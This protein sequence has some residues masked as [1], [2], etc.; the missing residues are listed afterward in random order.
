MNLHGRIS[1]R[2]D[3][4]SGWMLG[5]VELFAVGDGFDGEGI[6]VHFRNVHSSSDEEGLSGENE[7]EFVEEMKQ[8]TFQIFAVGFDGMRVDH[9]DGVDLLGDIS[10]HAHGRLLKRLFQVLSPAMDLDIGRVI[11]IFVLFRS[12]GEIPSLGSPWGV[13]FDASPSLNHRFPVL[14]PS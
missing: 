11:E 8:K 1:D 6:Q 9:V 10:I 2:L 4:R 13:P 12:R 5:E 14:G 7:E 3:L